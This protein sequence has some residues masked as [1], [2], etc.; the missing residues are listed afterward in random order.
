MAG[1][2]TL[3]HDAQS[4]APSWSSR[5]WRAWRPCSASK[6]FPN[7]VQLV[8]GGRTGGTTEAGPGPDPDYWAE[9]VGYLQPHALPYMT[10]HP[11]QDISGSAHLILAR[12]CALMLMLTLTL[13][14][15][16]RQGPELVCVYCAHQRDKERGL[17]NPPDLH[18]HVRL[19][20]LSQPHL[21][22]TPST[23]PNLSPTPTIQ[24][25]PLLRHITN[26]LLYQP[27][28]KHLLS[29]KTNT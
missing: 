26:A 25:P 14:C 21:S 16:H 15:T 4:D 12:S 19:V 27:S 23:D 6:D 22:K 8:P 10:G 1:E 2:L 24:P 7:I 18:L 5:P 13:T 3:N 17:A 20:R 28:I 9:I 29:S 11:P